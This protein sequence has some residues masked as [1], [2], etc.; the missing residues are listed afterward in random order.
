MYLSTEHLSEDDK[1]LLGLE[2]CD[3]VGD[4]PLR[5]IIHGTDVV[6]DPESAFDLDSDRWILT[7]GERIGHGRLGVAYRAAIS[8]DKQTRHVIAKVM[9]LQGT[10]IMPSD[11]DIIPYPTVAHRSIAAKVEA[12]AYL[13]LADLQGRSVP[14]YYGLFASSRNPEVLV[15]LMDDAGSEREHLGEGSASEIESRR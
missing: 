7:F 3:A 11:D 9:N 8:S 4:I 6:F 2:R 13:E 10:H 5:L 1:R 15:A 12:H 14:A